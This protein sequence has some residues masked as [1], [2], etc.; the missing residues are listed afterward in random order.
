MPTRRY[1]C[2]VE[3]KQDPR[4][5]D[6][7]AVLFDARGRSINYTCCFPKLPPSA[8]MKKTEK[9]LLAG[10]REL[11]LSGIGRRRR[12]RKRRGR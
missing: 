11:S 4:R 8:V 7:M 2:G 12:R 9:R 1:R 6:W 5:G 3:W 10:C